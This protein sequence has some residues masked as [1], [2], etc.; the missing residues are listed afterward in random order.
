MPDMRFAPPTQ[1]R[2]ADRMNGLNAERVRSYNERVVLSLLLQSG[3]ISRLEIGERTRLSAQTVSVIVRSLE[4]ERLVVAGQALR[5][6]V[7]PPTVPILL[8]GEGAYAV[9]ISLTPTKTDVVLIDFLGRDRFRTT[10]PGGSQIDAVTVRALRNAVQDATSTLPEGARNRLTGVGLCLPVVA[11]PLSRPGS[12]LEEERRIHAE[13]ETAI[14]LPV[15]VQDDIT[16]A[17]GAEMMFGGT[18]RTS[19]YLFFFVADV[20]YSRLV[21]NNHVYLGN[22]EVAPASH[23]VAAQVRPE[24]LRSTSSA[25]DK[26]AVNA[27]ISKCAAKLKTQALAISQFVN[28]GTIVVAGEVQAETIRALRAEVQRQLPTLKVVPGST[29]PH[30]RAIGAGSL[31]FISRFTIQDAAP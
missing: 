25:Q 2:I 7:G 17:A 16:A 15:F 21:L 14:G 29:S 19:D 18:K 6:R 3:G 24:A 26:E 10:L 30:A 13:L 20:L 1:L 28:L 27:W 8:N 23:E 4:Q 31:P 12:L 22:Y 9:G 5:G 11:T